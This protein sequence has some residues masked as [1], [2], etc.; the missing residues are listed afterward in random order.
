MTKPD[1]TERFATKCTEA[2]V[3]YSHA[4]FFAGLHAFNTAFETW[5]RACEA[6]MT[7]PNA[8]SKSWFRHPDEQT[9]QTAF[10]AATQPWA[11]LMATPAM[12]SQAATMPWWFSAPAVTQAW[13]DFMR[14]PQMTMTWPTADASPADFSVWPMTWSM[15]TAGVP[16]E[17]ARPTAEANAAA[18]D[19]MESAKQ[20]ADETVASV[21]NYTK[22]YR[23]ESRLSAP[24]KSSA[25]PN[26]PLALFR[27]WFTS[28]TAA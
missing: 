22:P 9:A 28:P 24:A 2:V 27:P 19:A 26:D 4:S 6:A 11:S 20:I 8:K 16:H 1:L 12:F 5:S 18:Y 13:A 10:E 23:V 7:L 17:V 21:S 15:V 14:T 3:G 25:D